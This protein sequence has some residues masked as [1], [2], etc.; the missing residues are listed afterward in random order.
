MTG[1]GTTWHV[2]THQLNIAN[3]L[4]HAGTAIARDAPL[5]DRLLVVYALGGSSRCPR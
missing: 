1:G 5:D 2:R 3:G 4:M